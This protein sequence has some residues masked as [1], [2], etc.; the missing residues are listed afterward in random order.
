MNTETT[1]TTLSEL[2][3]RINPTWDGCVWVVMCCEGDGDYPLEAHHLEEE[4]RARILVMGEDDA[5]ASNSPDWDGVVRSYYV[6]P[7]PL[8]S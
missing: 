1:L 4:A 6:T 5:W 2:A 3:A 8:L 7:V